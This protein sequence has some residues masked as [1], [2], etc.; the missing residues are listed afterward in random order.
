MSVSSLTE[1]RQGFLAALLS[2]PLA[3]GLV[4]LTLLTAGSIV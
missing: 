2:L 1:A 4:G 3:A